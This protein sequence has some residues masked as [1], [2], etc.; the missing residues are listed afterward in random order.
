[1][2]FKKKKSVILPNSKNSRDAIHGSIISC[3]FASNYGAIIRWV[4]IRQKKQRDWKK[5]KEEMPL[6][7]DWKA[8]GN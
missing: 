5:T 4:N 8:A 7:G 3:G 1:M 2:L 6:N